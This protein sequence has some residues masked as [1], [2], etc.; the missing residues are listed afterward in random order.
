MP[1]ATRPGPRP[2]A[3]GR[4]GAYSPRLR[5]DA[6]ATSSPSNA[7]VARS[8]NERLCRVEGDALLI[9]QLRYRY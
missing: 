6:V 3:R 4:C 2:V 9:A 7:M 8:E 5:I 1:A